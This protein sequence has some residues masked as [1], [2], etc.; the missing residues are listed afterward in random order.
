MIFNYYLLAHIQNGTYGCV[1]VVYDPRNKCLK[2]LKIERMNSTIP[3]QTFLNGISVH[4][5]VQH[6]GVIRVDKIFLDQNHDFCFTIMDFHPCSLQTVLNQL[7]VV[8][9]EKHL[10]PSKTLFDWEFAEGDIQFSS[11]RKLKDMLSYWSFAK[12]KR[13]NKNKNK[14]ESFSDM[15]LLQCNV[16]ERFAYPKQKLYFARVTLTPSSTPVFIP[17]SCLRKLEQQARWFDHWMHRLL[18]SPETSLKQIEMQLHEACAALV[19]QHKAGGSF[20]FDLKP[21]NVLVE[22]FSPKDFKRKKKL[23]Q[24]KL[25]DFNLAMRLHRPLYLRLGPI[26]SFTPVEWICE[27]RVCSHAVDPWSIGTI[28]ESLKHVNKHLLNPEIAKPPPPS[29]SKPLSSPTS[30]QNVFIEQITNLFLAPEE[31]LKFNLMKVFV[32][33]SLFHPSSSSSSSSPPLSSSVSYFDLSTS[34]ES[35]KDDDDTQ[36]RQIDQLSKTLFDQNYYKELLWSQSGY[37]ISFQQCLS[38]INKVDT[39]GLAEKHSNFEFPAQKRRHS[40]HVCWQTTQRKKCTKKKTW[41]SFY[42][43]FLFF[44]SNY[45]HANPFYLKN[46]LTFQV[47]NILSIAA[48]VLDHHHTTTTTTPKKQTTKTTSIQHL[49]FFDSEFRTQWTQWAVSYTY[50]NRYKPRIFLNQQSHLE[51][52][53]AFLQ[54]MDVFLSHPRCTAWT[55]QPFDAQDKPVVHHYGPENSSGSFRQERPVH[56]NWEKERDPPSSRALSSFLVQLTEE[57]EEVVDHWKI[58]TEQQSKLKFSKPKKQKILEEEDSWMQ[59]MHTKFTDKEL[60]EFIHPCRF[61]RLVVLVVMHMASA[62]TFCF[63]P[64]LY[65]QQKGHSEVDLL[66]EYLQR[67]ISQQLIVCCEGQIEGCSALFEI[68]QRIGETQTLLSNPSLYQQ[69]EKEGK[70]ASCDQS[71]PSL[72]PPT[73]L[74][75]E[76]GFLFLLQRP[77]EVY[78]KDPQKVL[79]FCHSLFFVDDFKTHLLHEEG[80]TLV[81]EKIAEG[82]GELLFFW[83]LLFKDISAKFA[84][85]WNRQ[86]FFE[87]ALNVHTMSCFLT[88]LPK[89]TPIFNMIAFFHEQLW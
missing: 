71:L 48:C 8:Q 51:C 45:V 63:Q 33:S 70:L 73:K 22:L 64:Q 76:R 66:L 83:S 57:E 25:I 2:A 65:F 23:F 20:H 61:F 39:L 87:H 54:L 3:E 78:Q 15:F 6:K 40:V 38:I 19:E 42:Q 47:E 55:T 11:F 18:R 43:P 56:M 27:D 41:A 32:P 44:E 81:L 67:Y 13:V 21:E 72:S 62:L 1:L 12:H 80:S 4:L 59:D 34:T 37:N 68:I 31:V 60:F 46:L 26:V 52:M 58:W 14:N 86:S 24:L 74:A 10:D 50:L 53:M 89:D 9:K 77:F 5:A 88:P 79:A 49:W 28:I 69:K 30:I 75:L 85:S 17:P 36:R 7:K 29:F 16:E 35:Q 84:F 82:W